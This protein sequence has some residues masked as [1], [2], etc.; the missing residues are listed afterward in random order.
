MNYLNQYALLH[1]TNAQN[2]IHIC[3]LTDQLTDR[4]DVEEAHRCSED[5]FEHA[6]VQRLC[7]PHQHVEQE[8]IPNKTKND[9]A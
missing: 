7:T 6:V 1:P 9:D 4:V 2:T 3:V 8:H 5:G